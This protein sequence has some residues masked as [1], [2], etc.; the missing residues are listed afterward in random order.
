[1]LSRIPLTRVPQPLRTTFL[2]RAPAQTPRPDACPSSAVD[3]LLPS[4]QLELEAWL[5][6]TLADLASIR[7]DGQASER[8]RPRP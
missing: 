5:N 3:L 4:A 6:D 1:M 8:L 2:P 7:D